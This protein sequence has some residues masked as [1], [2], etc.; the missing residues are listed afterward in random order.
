ML[1]FDFFILMR[2]FR[3]VFEKFFYK[4]IKFCFIIL[5]K[6]FVMLSRL[7]VF[8]FSFNDVILVGG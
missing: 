8:I 6:I 1:L 5:Y 4:K 2:D 3:K 7:L